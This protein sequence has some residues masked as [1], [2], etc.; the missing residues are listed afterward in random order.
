MIDSPHL[1]YVSGPLARAGI[2][3]LYQSSYFC[4]YLLCKSEDFD[5]VATI[6]V[7]QGC[8]SSRT[9]CVSGG[10]DDI[11][12]VNDADPI[13]NRRRSGLYT[14]HSATSGR[15]GSPRVS[16][17]PPPSPIPTSP[18]I[19][20]LSAPLACVGFAKS[21]ER[22]CN[23]RLRKYITWPERSLFEWEQQRLDLTGD[24][25]AVDQCRGRPFVS[26]TRTED[27]TSLVTE[28]KA[29]RGMFP[30]GDMEELDVQCAGELSCDD[31]NED[32]DDDC[33][34][35][36]E[37]ESE[38]DDEEGQAEVEYPILIPSIDLDHNKDITMSSYLPNTNIPPTPPLTASSTTSSPGKKRLSLPLSP[39]SEIEIPFSWSRRT[40]RSMSLKINQSMA[41][42]G[43]NQK[44]KTRM[45]GETRGNGTK[46]CLQLD[47][48]G[49]SSSAEEAYHLG[50]FTPS[51]LSI[52]P[53]TSS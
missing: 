14:P 42:D 22:A 23:E 17:S 11:G 6:F 49:V 9:C 8:E 52:R 27:G 29:L 13:P 37:S 32:D 36:S 28:V 12:Q 21:A 31:E 7:S 46:R 3:I 41:I 45:H 26:Y 24:D 43:E 20:V 35:E 33:D 47:L 10:I 39:Q 4:D 2:S 53:V 16:A 48:R 38:S 34:S 1:R 51:Y 18:E 44:K 19:T 40:T 25:R 5:K 50:M 15:S 30:A